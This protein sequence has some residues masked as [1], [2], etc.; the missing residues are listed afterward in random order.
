MA[1]NSSIARQ[2]RTALVSR[3]KKCRWRTTSFPTSGWLN[4]ASAEEAIR[5]QFMNRIVNMKGIGC[6]RSELG[7]V[8]MTDAAAV[9]AAGTLS[10][11]AAPTQKG[12]GKRE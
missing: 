3:E 12:L 9:L 2:V 4:T 7:E 1:G 11:R 10:A 6:V 8:L 5:D